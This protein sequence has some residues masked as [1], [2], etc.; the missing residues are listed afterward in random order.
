MLMDMSHRSDRQL[1]L[2]DYYQLKSGIAIWSPGSMISGRTPL[3][4]KP[5]WS[6]C[7]FNVSTY[8]SLLQANLEVGDYG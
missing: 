3:S 1:Y 6:R 5:C 4:P 8:K 2:I 7:P